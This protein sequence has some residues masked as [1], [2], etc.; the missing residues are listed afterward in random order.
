MFNLMQE[1]G[2]EKCFIVRIGNCNISGSYDRYSNVIQWQNEIC[3]DYKN[4]DLI[5]VSTN[6]ASMRER[7][8]MKDQFHYYQDGYNEVGNQAGINTGLYVT[9]GK[10]PL[11]YDSESENKI[12]ASKKM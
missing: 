2:I 7:G 11:M 9:T 5:M 12:Y 8:M 6:F 1:H 3:S 4:K 10:E